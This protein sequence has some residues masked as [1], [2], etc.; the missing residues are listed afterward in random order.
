MPIPQEF[1]DRNALT[2]GSRVAVRLVGRRL[3]VEVPGRSRYRVAN[4]MS[5]LPGALSGVEGRNEL[6]SVGAEDDSSVVRS[7]GNRLWRFAASQENVDRLAMRLAFCVAALGA[8]VAIATIVATI[9][10]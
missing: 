6:P 8:V 3:I 7:A 1:L 10:K 2:D 4:R 5:E 9:A